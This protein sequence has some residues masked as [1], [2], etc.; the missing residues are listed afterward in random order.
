LSLLEPTTYSVADHIGGGKADIT[1][2]RDPKRTKNLK[3]LELVY[4]EVKQGNMEPSGIELA[5]AQGLVFRIG[6]DS[7]IVVTKTA[8]ITDEGER[9]LHRAFRNASPP[10]ASRNSNS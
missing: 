9:V 10:E 5:S 6:T 2:K 4:V 3:K 7:R 8:Q 1:V